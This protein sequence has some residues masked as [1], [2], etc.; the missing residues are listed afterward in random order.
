MLGL[1]KVKLLKTVMKKVL[2]DLLHGTLPQTES[3]LQAECVK[4]FKNTYRHL[5][6][7]YYQVKNDGKKHKVA[8]SL[9]KAM[10]VTA[11]IP[12]THLAVARGK[13]HSLYVE[14]K[15]ATGRISPAQEEVFQLL[16][17]EG[18]RVEVVR[19]EAEFQALIN[20]YLHLK[21]IATW[22]DQTESRETRG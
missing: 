19:S 14:F 17:A 6:L 7:L 22:E 16:E 11:G 21:N 3:R 9:D 20:E 1:S 10:G 2:N 5:R 8:G 15:T 12:D 4:W 18:H 13:W